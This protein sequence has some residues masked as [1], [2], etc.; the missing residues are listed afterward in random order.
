[1]YLGSPHGLPAPSAQDVGLKTCHA[2]CPI[3][4]LGHC[5]CWGLSD[6]AGDVLLVPGSFAHAR[7]RCPRHRDAPVPTVRCS[8]VADRV[9]IPTCPQEFS[10]PVESLALTV[11]EMINVRRVLVKAEM[12]KFLQSKELYS[13]LRK[14]KVGAGARGAECCLPG[15]RLSPRSAYR[16]AAAAG[17]SSPS[18]PGP[19]HASS[20]SG[21]CRAMPQGWEGGRGVPTMVP[22]T[23]FSLSPQVCM[24]L[25]QPE[26]KGLALASA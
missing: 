8:P 5:W 21:E 25:L 26:G 17:P 4:M 7:R 16:S 14:G 20:V 3:S 15:P 13:S 23:S 24:Q 2:M 6:R 22:L 10:H 19:Q 12:E 1:M 9:D 11:E 18:S